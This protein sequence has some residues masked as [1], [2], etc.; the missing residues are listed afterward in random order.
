MTENAKGIALLAM[1]TLLAEKGELNEAIEKLEAIPDMGTSNFGVRVAGIESMIG[2]NLEMGQDATALKLVDKFDV[3]NARVNAAKGLIEF[4]LGNIDKA[5]MC[6][7]GIPEDEHC[8][9]NVMLSRGEFLHA[10]GDL[11]FAKECYKKAINSTP[12]N[13]VFD[14]LHCLSACNMVPNEVMLGATCALGQLEAHSGNFNDAEETLT[15]ALTIAEKQFGSRHPK[16]GVI[17]TCI[18]LMFRHKAKLEH[19]SSILIQEGLYRKAIDTLHAPSLETED[20][21]SELRRIDMVALARGGYAE[22]LSVQGNRKAEGDR[23]R[24]WAE[25]AWRNRRLTL[26]DALDIS[27]PSSKVAVVDTRICRAL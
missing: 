10:T 7:E 21:E 14:D 25:K 9:G 20:A 2:L 4:V 15:K 5:K 1:S 18:A 3:L 26:A 11:T 8:T 27:D 24:Q 19:S 23:M 17:L 6:F 12:E 13:E 22:I 16:V